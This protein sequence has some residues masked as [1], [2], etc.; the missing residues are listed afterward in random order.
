MAFA[1]QTPSRPDG[2]IDPEPMPAE[3]HGGGAA[4]VLAERAR[5]KRRRRFLLAAAVLVL[6]GG[7]AAAWYALAPRK[8]P[9]DGVL[10]AP[11]RQGDVE[12]TISA[13]GRLQPR[14][15]VDVGA[16]VSGQLER[17][18][19]RV[20]EKVEKGQLL[21]RINPTVLLAK[22]ESSRAEIRALRAQLQ[23]QIAARDLAELQAQRQRRM[24][25]DNATSADALETAQ[26]ALKTARARV[27]KLSAD[28]DR[29]TSSLK[30]DEATLGYTRIYAP[31]AGTVVSIAAQ[32]GQTLNAA[33]QTPVILR[34]ADLSAMTVRTQV[35]EADVSK[36]A[37]GMEVYFTTLGD[38]RRRWRS[39]LG[40]V[41][42]APEVVN[43]VV[44]YT[45]LFDID[46]A[47]GDLMTE[48]S[49]QVYFV[50]GR[51]DDVLTVPV[52]ALQRGEEPGSYTVSVVG[53]N[54]VIE[55]RAVRI[56]V[57]NRIRAEVLSGLKAGERVIAG[58][59]RDAT[60]GGRKRQRR[61]R[62]RL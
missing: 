53:D 21:A 27:T 17:L 34:I 28:I 15:F 20:G 10:T 2:R 50:L 22:V 26:A 46:N 51:A 59:G 43:N 13:L 60:S 56:G 61:R 16:Q 58:R 57:R 30:A 40:Q 29:Q 7:S 62:F 3:H 23:E 11:V 18:E 12:N 35:S 9:L 48:M 49:A 25:R 42:P 36:L 41:L 37:P 55:Q 47:G 38:R 4:E 32:Q 54:D 44:L 19:V 8:G 39:K 14:D 24:M 33:Q 31:I 45:A 6:A 1:D 5:R 52:S